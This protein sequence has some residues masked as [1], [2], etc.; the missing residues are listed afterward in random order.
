MQPKRGQGWVFTSGIQHKKLIKRSLLEN[1]SRYIILY[2]HALPIFYT[3]ERSWHR[4]HGGKMYAHG[5]FFFFFFFFFFC[6]LISHYFLLSLSLSLPFLLPF[7]AHFV[8]W[9]I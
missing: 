2:N 1:E 4:D 8:C 9:A 5:D 6:D 7:L 3:H